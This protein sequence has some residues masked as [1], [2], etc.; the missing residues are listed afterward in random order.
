MA[1]FFVIN[2][3]E[4]IADLSY[5]FISKRG[6]YSENESIRILKF[7]Q[8]YA[9]LRHFPSQQLILNQLNYPMHD[10]PGDGYCF[11]S[12]QNHSI[13]GHFDMTI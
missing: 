12:C 5:A 6:A 3:D 9:D 7:H 10:V 1:T 11:F 8:A 13:H 4:M 2:I